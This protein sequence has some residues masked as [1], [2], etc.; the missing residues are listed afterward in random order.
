MNSI[1]GHNYNILPITSKE[2][3]QNIF[4]LKYSKEIKLYESK[5]IEN[6]N[7]NY[8]EEEK[9]IDLKNSE[10]INKNEI[11]IIRDK[12]KKINEDNKFKYYTLYIP[13]EALETGELENIQ[14]IELIDMPGIKKE[15]LEFGKMD[16]KSLINLS[17][18]FIFSFNSI[19]IGDNDSQNLLTNIINYIKNRK[20]S[21]DFRDCLFHLNNIDSCGDNQDEIIKRKS[22]FETEIKKNLNINLYNGNFLERI[23]MREIIPSLKFNISYI[24]NTLYEAYQKKVHKIES[25]EFIEIEDDLNSLQ[26]ISD[27]LKDEYPIKEDENENHDK[28]LNIEKNKI[29]NKLNELNIE[30]NDGLLKEI[31]IH[32][33]TILNKKKSFFK[34]YKISY[35]D[36]FL[37]EFNKQIKNSE[38]NNKLVKYS[39]FISYYLRIFYY[40][41][42]IDSLCLDTN[43]INLFHNRINESKELL[44]KIYEKRDRQ[45]DNK[46]RELLEKISSI[47]STITT[48]FQPNRF[49]FKV[50]SEEEIKNFIKKENVEII[51][52]ELINNLTKIL[53]SLIKEFVKEN[54]SIISDLLETNEF[55]NL[56]INVAIKFQIPNFKT[57]WFKNLVGTS[58]ILTIFPI[59][60]FGVIGITIYNIARYNRSR[61]D[62]YFNDIRIDLDK[63]KND[64]KKKIKI[65]KNKFIEKL[66]NLKAISLKEIEYLNE[67]NFHDNF[68]NLMNK[69]IQ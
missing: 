55:E 21:F 7:G 33:L 56:L 40:L 36:S 44:K 13:I 42:Y 4:I 48:K 57:H 2:N 39:K 62:D 46:F 67:R 14:D 17:N 66:D 51:L 30:I 9:E 3:T 34:E 20:D 69:F 12:I 6:E 10:E 1:I 41:F 23:H 45:I 49:S 31:A 37:N 35:Y 50:K 24:S 32:I 54:L 19:N 11:D 52:S 29:K 63:Y 59:A 60:I 5:L 64:Y 22:S 18:G 15:L 43:K 27:Y 61:L 25:L 58:L 16:L 28:N 68:S 8:F 38:E 47:Q 65:I 26:A 53:D